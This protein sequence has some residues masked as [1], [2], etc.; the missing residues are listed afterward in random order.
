M[1]TLK[2]DILAFLAQFK[3]DLESWA[4]WNA[5]YLIGSCEEVLPLLNT[6]QVTQLSSLTHRTG[7]KPTT[8]GE[9]ESTGSY[10]VIV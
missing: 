4:G 5:P 1:V 9:A 8:L 3:C 6:Y 10:I 7:M 2:C